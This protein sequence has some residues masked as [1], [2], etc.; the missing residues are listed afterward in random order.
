[1]CLFVCG[2]FFCFVLLHVLAALPYFIGVDFGARRML[3]L[4]SATSNFRVILISLVEVDIMSLRKE[5]FICIIMAA[6]R[7]KD[8]F[9][10]L[11]WKPRE[12]RYT[13][14]PYSGERITKVTRVIDEDVSYCVY[15][16]CQY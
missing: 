16:F 4:A 10:V 11:T 7:P 3:S 13:N 2:F 8:L 14:A 6:T 15:G 12:R 9:S 1:M 5:E